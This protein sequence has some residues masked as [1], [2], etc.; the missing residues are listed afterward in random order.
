[1]VTTT[2]ELARR[3]LKAIDHLSGASQWR[4]VA[5]WM[6]EVLGPAIGMSTQERWQR[7]R[8]DER[9]VLC[10]AL[11]GQARHQPPAPKRRLLGLFLMPP[12][13]AGAFRP[14]LIRTGTPRDFPKLLAHEPSEHRC[15]AR[16]C[17]SPC[18]PKFLMCPRHWKMVPLGLQRAVWSA[19]RP[20]QEID[21]RPSESWHRAA[22]AA[23]KAVAQRELIKRS[24]YLQ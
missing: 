16:G 15:H 12:K 6:D 17:S 8:A 4:D 19:Y 14:T 2:D 21:R 20:G 13:G 18:P 1:M 11:E 22:D 5:K 3:A 23:I 10:D 7:M 9:K 24:R